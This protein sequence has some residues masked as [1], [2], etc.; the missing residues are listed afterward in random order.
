MVRDHVAQR[1][2]SFKVGAAPL[3]ADRLGIRDLHVVDVAPVPDGLENRVVEAEDHDVLH[4][5]FAEVVID[6]V[7]LVLEQHAL[8]VAV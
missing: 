7:D 4:G 5:L 8:D 2:C 3:H 1:S 6:A